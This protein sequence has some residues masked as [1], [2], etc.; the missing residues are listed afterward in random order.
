[1]Q[2]RGAPRAGAAAS[3]SSSRTVSRRRVIVCVAA[4]EGGQK[5]QR[6][7]VLGGTGRVGSNAAASLLANHG[8]EYEVAVA[9]RSRE[10]YE[11]A[12]QRKPVLKDA[13]YVPCD[14][15]DLASVKVGAV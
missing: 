11:A 4:A 14:I 6:V 12:V 7:V 5:K 2:L 15:G 9:G 1:M 3:S 8:A 10:N 13:A